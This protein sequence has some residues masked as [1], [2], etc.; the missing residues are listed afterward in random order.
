M[1]SG[2]RPAQVVRG[3]GTVEQV[4]DQ[5][6]SLDPAGPA[7]TYHVLSGFGPQGDVFVT[8]RWR[9][10]ELGPGRLKHDPSYAIA[11]CPR[12]GRKDKT[13]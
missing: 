9:T 5:E 11:D 2:F 3:F 8:F 7:G 4:G 1:P 10:A 6:F 12:A 13:G